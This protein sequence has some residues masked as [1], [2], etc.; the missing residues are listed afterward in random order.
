MALMLVQNMIHTNIKNSFTTQLKREPIHITIRCI[1][2]FDRMDRDI[3]PRAFD[4]LS[5]KYKTGVKDN[6]YIDDLCNYI[7]K[8]ID[9][10][11]GFTSPEPNT[12]ENR[13][14]ETLSEPFVATRWG[15]CIDDRERVLETFREMI[16]DILKESE[17]KIFEKFKGSVMSVS[18]WVDNDILVKHV[19]DMFKINIMILDARTNNPYSMAIQ[20]SD[21]RPYIL[22]YYI[23]GVH[24]EGM[25]I[26][27]NNTKSIQRK[28]TKDDR[29]VKWF[30]DKMN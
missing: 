14:R 6:D 21:S 11:T 5:K 30:N 16:V 15:A 8:Y 3:L 20:Y 22:L 2:P 29:I 7:V 23:P 27:N 25:G 1:C 24:F 28:F 19:S 17:I 12:E 18:T 9:I 26:Y 13:D 4:L 10:F